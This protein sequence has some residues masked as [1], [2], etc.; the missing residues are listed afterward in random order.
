[1]EKLPRRPWFYY[2]FNL[3]LQDRL[4]KFSLLCFEKIK[5]VN[6][7]FIE[8]LRGISEIKLVKV[9]WINYITTYDFFSEA[10]LFIW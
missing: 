10:N 7:L 2:C 5:L 4:R 1:M 8:N 6:L 3:I 9:H